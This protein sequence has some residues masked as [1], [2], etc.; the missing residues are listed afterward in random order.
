MKSTAALAAAL[1]DLAS[2]TDALGAATV[3]LSHDEGKALSA[4]ESKAFLRA[5]CAKAGGMRPLA[6]AMNE[7]RRGAVSAPS[8]DRTVACPV[9]GL[10]HLV[11]AEDAEGVSAQ[12]AVMTAHFRLEV[13]NRT[14][15]EFKLFVPRTPVTFV[16]PAKPRA[17]RVRA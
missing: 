4:A 15:G 8:N 13:R 12:D 2:A 14:A 3:W 6:D 9:C 10:S 7:V 16:A 5:C 11:T 17:K 1:L